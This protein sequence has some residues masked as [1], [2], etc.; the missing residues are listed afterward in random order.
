MPLLAIE[1]P[2]IMLLRRLGTGADH[3]ERV[4]CQCKTRR[5]GGTSSTLA[6]NRMRTGPT[7]HHADRRK[8]K[9]CI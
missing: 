5:L 2:L 3:V 4:H 9:H 8:R 7:R 6:E 1:A